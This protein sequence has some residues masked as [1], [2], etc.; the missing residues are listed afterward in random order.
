MVYDSVLLAE[1]CQYV[2]LSNL[3]LFYTSLLTDVLSAA[4]IRIA[5]RLSSL[6]DYLGYDF[7]T[8]CHMNCIDNAVFGYYK[9]LSFLFY[10]TRNMGIFLLIFQPLEFLS[11]YTIVIKQQ[12]Y[13]FRPRFPAL[14]HDFL[15]NIIVLDLAGASYATYHLYYIHKSSRNSDG[16][17]PLVIRR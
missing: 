7:E 17:S 11:I 14:S 9:A 6:I 13:H 5:S 2:P 15:K 16:E 1:Y 4:D 8:V 3:S 10:L 12:L